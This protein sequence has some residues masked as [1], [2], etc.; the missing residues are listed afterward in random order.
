MR[1]QREDFRGRLVKLLITKEDAMDIDS[2]DAITA[3]EKETLRY[4]YYIRHGVDTVHVAPL[5][6]GTLNNVGRKLENPS[7]LL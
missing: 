4:Y 1:K 7:F 6:Q 5:D 3:E 2:K